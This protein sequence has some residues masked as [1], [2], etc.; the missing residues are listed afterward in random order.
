ML[1]REVEIREGYNILYGAGDD[2]E[3]ALGDMWMKARQVE[4]GFEIISTVGGP[5][6]K[7]DDM[8]KNYYIAIQ[9]VML[10]RRA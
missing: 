9:A 4:Q 10:R 7:Q 3:S 5:T 2:A 8:K 1:L 6:F